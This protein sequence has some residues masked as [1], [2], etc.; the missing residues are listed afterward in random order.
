[1]K[2]IVVLLLLVSNLW[3]LG[4]GVVSLRGVPAAGPDERLYLSA[5]RSF[6]GGHWSTSAIWL[7]E[8]VDR[9]PNSPRRPKAAL[10]LGQSYYKQKYYKQAYAALSNNRLAAGGLADQYVYWMAECRVGQGSWDAADQ[11]FGE[12]LREFP[13][14][15]RRLESTISSAFIAAQR[16]DWSRVISLLRPA[17]GVFQAQLGNG[18]ENDL[19]Q[20]GCLLLSGAFLEQKDPRSAKLLLGLLPRVM[21]K[22]RTRRKELLNLRIMAASGSF[23]EVMHKLD[24]L[25]HGELEWLIQIVRLKVALLIKQKKWQTAA[26][27]CMSLSSEELSPAVREE[28]YLKSALYSFCG[29]DREAAKRHLKSIFSH[30]D[31]RTSFGLVNCILGEMTLEEGGRFQDALNYFELADKGTADLEIRA[32]SLWGIGRCYHLSGDSDR[33]LDYHYRALSVSKDNVLRACILYSQGLL[34]MGSGDWA[35]AFEDFDG[36]TNREEPQLGFNDAVSYMKIKATLRDSGAPKAKLILDRFR[37]D[38]GPLYDNAL[39]LM[40]QDA[41]SRGRLSDAD[42]LLVDFRQGEP[43]KGLLA[44]A[45]LEHIRIQVTKKKWTE[46]LAL[47][48]KWLKDYPDSELFAKVKIDRAWVLNKSGQAKAAEL[49]Y[50]EVA[51]FRN[52][53]PEV[54]AAKIWLADKA[55]NTVTNRI[56]AE[57]L[58]QEVAGA[59]NGPVRLR[60]RAQMMAGR[61]AVARQG[62]D[63]ARKSFSVLLSNPSTTDNI[64][65]QAIFALGDLT[66]IDIGSSAEK[67]LPRLIQSTNAFYS[68]V[69]ISPTNK[70]AAKAWGKIGDGCLLISKDHPNYLSHAKKAYEKSLSVPAEIEVSTSSQAHM[71]LAYTIE[72][73]AAREGPESELFSGALGHF[74]TVFYGR[75]LGSGQ[76]HDPYWRGQSGLAAL[77]ILEKLKRYDQAHKLCEELEVIFPGMKTGLRARKVRLGKIRVKEP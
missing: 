41:V 70:L 24:A 48:D 62:Y 65:S 13:N 21:T 56:Y 16:E 37:S 40:A 7:K 17:S 73:L 68:L 8:L 60:Q 3:P 47:Y 63:D 77:R 74:L 76:K 4:G 49:A 75:H 15:S 52:I 45:E 12:L 59:T 23:P 32:R 67:A 43:G 35:G 29:G 11:I 20:E 42:N 46:S 66:L 28:L 5:V 27:E 72:R 58:Y 34:K 55:F 6:H 19:L 71:G 18:A 10:L 54:F 51:S 30:P 69:K 44:A 2:V 31:L 39:L 9:Y 22:D 25:Q 50:R 14:S 36:V 61:A 53:S 64:R 1:M 33:A 38:S 26:Q 57:R